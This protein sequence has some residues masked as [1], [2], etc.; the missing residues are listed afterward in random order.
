MVTDSISDFIIQLK[1][2]SSARK[3]SFSVPHSKFKAAIAEVLEKEGFIK[4]ANKKGKKVIKTLEIELVYENG[5][6]KV[7]DVKRV[8]KISKRLYYGVDQIRSVRQGFGRLILSTP[9]GILT[10]REAKKAKVGGEPLFKIW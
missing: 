7:N 6:P 4:S 3:Q 5:A 8:S 2:A 9:K 1:N 10:D